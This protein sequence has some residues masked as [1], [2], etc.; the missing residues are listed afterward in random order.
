MPRYIDR[1]AQLP[2]PPPDG[3]AALRS[4]V[5]AP[6][7]ARGVKGVN[8]LFASDGSGYCIFDAPTADAVVEAH[9]ASGLPVARADVTEI[10]SLI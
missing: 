3:L 4:R 6:A 9:A 2:L 8:I 1:H 10:A 7:D 5:E